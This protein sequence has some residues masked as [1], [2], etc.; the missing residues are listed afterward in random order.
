M[1]I[2]LLFPLNTKVD[3]RDP[4]SLVV[5]V[6]IYLAVCAVVKIADLLLGW[7][8]LIGGILWVLFWLIGLYCA[9]GIILA[10]LEFF[11]GDSGN[12]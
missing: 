12:P 1:N 11:R 4:R 5:V 10:L 9:V 6:C 2:N 3:Q 7:I 8:P